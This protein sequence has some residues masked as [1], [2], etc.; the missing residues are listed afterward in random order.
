MDYETRLEWS[1]PRLFNGSR[2][3][4]HVIAIK[5]KRDSAFRFSE[6]DAWDTIWNDVEATDRHARIAERAA[7][8]RNENEGLLEALPHEKV[9]PP[10]IRR[11]R[12]PR[13]RG[14]QAET[15]G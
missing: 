6:R 1:E 4:Y 10:L 12:R 2:Q 9:Y 11:F 8:T 14:P 7:N 5:D 15:I 3:L 13:P